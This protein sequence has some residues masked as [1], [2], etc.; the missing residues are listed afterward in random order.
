MMS[1]GGVW[2]QIRMEKALRAH[3]SLL[4]SIVSNSEEQS[5]A[6]LK[7]YCEDQEQIL[8]EIGLNLQILITLP[9][10]QTRPLLLGRLGV[11]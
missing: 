7:S 2:I 1:E 3:L 9:E 11:N 5:E 8:C 10:L 4:K 6:L